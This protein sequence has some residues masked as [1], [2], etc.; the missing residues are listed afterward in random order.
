MEPQKK[1]SK[2][3][4]AA[5]GKKRWAFTAYVNNEDGTPKEPVCNHAAII[6]LLKARGVSRF[7]FQLEI[8]EGG[9]HHYQGR[10]GF[11]QSHRMTA[12]PKDFAI[13]WG[14][15]ADAAGSTFYATDVEKRA[16][17]PWTDK[18]EKQTMSER[19]KLRLAPLQLRA[20]QEIIVNDIGQQNDRQITMVMDVWGQSGKGALSNWLEINRG[21]IIIP[22][23]MMTAEDVVQYVYCMIEDDD[24][25]KDQILV[26]DI[27]RSLETTKKWASWFAGIETLKDGKV[28]DKRFSAK[29]K[30]IC[31]PKVVVLCN[32]F[33]P[34]NGLSV[35]RWRMYFMD[36]DCIVTRVKPFTVTRLGKL[37][38]E[39]K[40]AGRYTWKPRMAEDEGDY[41]ELNEVSFEDAITRNAY[42]GCYVPER[43][44]EG[45]DDDAMDEDETDEEE[46]NE[47]ETDLPEPPAADDELDVDEFMADMEV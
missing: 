38:D 16:A 12:L 42:G 31:P 8:G 2:P 36:Y 15:E 30:R 21:A 40:S 45:D 18:T 39:S 47:N 34:V 4:A 29:A 46:V 26:M 9:R 28:Y 7:C 44:T 11:K 24:D 3:A 32:D 17:G 37:M 27:P 22:S 6:A 14:I 23:T 35:D 43:E 13:H 5:G 33:P 41:L 19:L 10:A 1:K 20:W 25:M